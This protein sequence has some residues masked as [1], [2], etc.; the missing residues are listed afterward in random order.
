MKR[1]YTEKKSKFKKQ[2][3]VNFFENMISL[4]VFISLMGRL[5]D[6]CVNFV[7]RNV[8]D[9]CTS[10][11]DPISSLFCNTILYYVLFLI[12]KTTLARLLL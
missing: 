2:P 5:R 9:T 12:Y 4:L 8:L 10:N 11:L 7:S 1:F 6:G 3:V